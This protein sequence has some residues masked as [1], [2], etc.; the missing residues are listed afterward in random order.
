MVSKKIPLL[1]L[2]SAAMLVIAVVS[3]SQMPERAGGIWAFERPNAP[4]G[5]KYI[6]VTGCLPCHA[7]EALGNQYRRWIG[8]KHM[9]TYVMLASP[10]G[11]MIMERMGFY[12]Y[13]Q[14]TETCLGCHAFKPDTSLTESTFKFEEG[15]QC[16]TCHGPGSVHIAR[17]KKM[18]EERPVDSGWTMGREKSVDSG[19][20]KIT[21]EICGQCHKPKPSHE[22]LPPRHL[23][24]EKAWKMIAHPIPETTEDGP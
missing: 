24:H 22:V 10:Y 23:G 5:A 8:S 2:V 12:G 13:A 9:R 21:K 19:F 6:G 14:E 4:P 20:G 17:M 16:E 1:I 3:W 18:A 11:R 15:V 7:E